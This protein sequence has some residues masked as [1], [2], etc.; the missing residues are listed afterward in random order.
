MAPWSRSVDFSCSNTARTGASNSQ[1]GSTLAASQESVTL[2][3]ALAAQRP[4]A[5]NPTLAS[6][7]NNL[8]NFLTDLGEREKALAAAQEAVTLYSALGA[9]RPDAFAPALAKLLV[10]LGT[11]LAQPSRP[12]DAITSLAEAVL[13]LTP[14]FVRYPSAIAPLMRHILREY[15]RAC[16]AASVE[17]DWQ[18]LAPLR[19]VFEQLK[20]TNLD[21]G[22]TE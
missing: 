12:A 20:S 5:F 19:A 3:G 10:L 18:L 2:Y 8:A 16:E 6:S 1:S 17:P 21:Q 9:Q 7:L 13:T 4:D 11:K 22:A 14:T 15:Q